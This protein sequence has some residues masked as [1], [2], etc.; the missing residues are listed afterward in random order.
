MLEV[1]NGGMTDTEY[2]S[3]FSLWAIMAAPLIAGNDL[4]NMDEATKH[5]E[6]ISE[7]TRKLQTVMAVIVED[8]SKK[9]AGG[10]GDAGMAKNIKEMQ[11]TLRILVEEGNEGR[12]QTC[13]AYIKRHT[14]DINRLRSFHRKPGVP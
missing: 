5:L 12:I 10:G 11:D 1:G 14:S 6:N 8:L 7:R 9:D 3:H 4:S 13:H 2:R